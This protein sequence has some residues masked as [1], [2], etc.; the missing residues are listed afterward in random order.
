[1]LVHDTRRSGSPDIFIDPRHVRHRL[2]IQTRHYAQAQSL[3]GCEKN[4]KDPRKMNTP[5]LQPAFQKNDNRTEPIVGG[6]LRSDHY[7]DYHP[8]PYENVNMLTPPT[9]CESSSF[10]ENLREI[11]IDLDDEIEEDERTTNQNGRDSPSYAPNASIKISEEDQ[12]VFFGKKMKSSIVK[13]EA[14]KQ[15]D[16]HYVNQV[17]LLKE[18]AEELRRLS[19]KSSKTVNNRRTTQRENETT[20]SDITQVR[21]LKEKAEELRRKASAISGNDNRFDQHSHEN[22][23][24]SSHHIDKSGHS[25]VSFQI[26]ANNEFPKPS[27][28]THGNQHNVGTSKRAFSNGQEIQCRTQ[29]PHLNEPPKSSFFDNLILNAFANVEKKTEIEQKKKREINERL[30]QSNSVISE[31][32]LARRVES[33]VDRYVGSNSSKSLIASKLANQPGSSIISTNVSINTDRSESPTYRPVTPPSQAETPPYQPATPPRLE[34][35]ENMKANRNIE[36]VCLS[37]DDESEDIRIGA[38]SSTNKTARNKEQTQ[39][40]RQNVPTNSSVSDVDIIVD[41]DVTVID[42]ESECPQRYKKSRLQ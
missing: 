4:D 37:S 22:M 38:S 5:V 16:R 23:P 25:N 10:E 13:T 11:I 36:V 31:D 20:L 24:S 32:D 42:L 34:E 12:Q 39:N 27:M 1:M 29:L 6:Q 8:P 18:K 19:S 2:Q 9:S 3:T 35:L 14:R 40:V 28:N 41:D 26:Y 33:F 15:Q 7:S 21:Q 17:R 30:L